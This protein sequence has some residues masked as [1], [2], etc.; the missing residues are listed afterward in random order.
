MSSERAFPPRC[1]SCASKL[2]VVQLDCPSCEAQ[3]RGDFDTCPVCSLEGESRRIFD[4]FL[5]ARGNLKEVQRRLG[6][7]YP[8]VRQRVDE[9]FRLIEGE[10]EPPEPSSVLARL[11]AGE[12]DVDEAE[13]LLRGEG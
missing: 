1:P 13:R 9:V 8:T 5:A 10:P 7:S 3:V 4:L 12:I 2:R 6:V 11:K